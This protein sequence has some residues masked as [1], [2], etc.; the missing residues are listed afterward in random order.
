LIYIGGGRELSI[1]K[2]P[3]SEMIKYSYNIF[4]R[5]P[6]FLSIS[7]NDHFFSLASSCKLVTKTKYCGTGLRMVL[8]DSDGEIY[9]CVNH[10]LPEFKAGNIHDNSFSDIWEKSPV[11]NRLR[12]IYP[13]DKN[14]KK[15]SN[16][17]IRH[18]CKGGCRGETYHV[19]KSLNSC[20]IDCLEIRKSII[21]MFWIL[22]GDSSFCNQ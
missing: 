12:T 18:W 16:C 19:T 13:V 5:N 6:E 2:I 1:K 15:C 9:P 21:E 22:S 11:L 10:R 4:K 8:L 3:M 14:N 7:G 17:I 20:S